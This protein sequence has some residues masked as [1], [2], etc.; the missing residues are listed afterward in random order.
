MIC[1]ACSVYG[2][3]HRRIEFKKFSSAVLTKEGPEQNLSGEQVR[4]SKKGN[5]EK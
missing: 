1:E 3:A 4:V 5:V 2:N